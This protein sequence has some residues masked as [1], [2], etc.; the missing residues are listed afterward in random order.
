MKFRNKSPSLGCPIKNGY[1]IK[2]EHVL[3]MYYKCIINE[4][5]TN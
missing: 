4:L 5:V 3:L 1:R 2:N